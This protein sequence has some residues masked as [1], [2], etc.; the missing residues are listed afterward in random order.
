MAKTA[1][2]EG[3]TGFDDLK[4]GR[5]LPSDTDQST[6]KIDH[7]IFTSPDLPT[8]NLKLACQMIDAVLRKKAS[9]SSSLVNFCC[10]LA[11]IRA[12][13]WTKAPVEPF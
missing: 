1:K 10:G 3:S 2:T 5:Y 6:S 7:S 8:D 11:L 9:K 13:V 4:L 12:T